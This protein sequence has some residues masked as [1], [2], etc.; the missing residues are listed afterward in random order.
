VIFNLRLTLLTTDSARND[1]SICEGTVLRGAKYTIRRR[2]NPVESIHD[3]FDK[4]RK[5]PDYVAGTVFVRDDFAPEKVEKIK[6]STSVEEAIT[7]A[8]FEA[9]EFVTA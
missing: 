2:I 7:E 5:H 8:G 6:E 1:G 9:A 3:L 4:V